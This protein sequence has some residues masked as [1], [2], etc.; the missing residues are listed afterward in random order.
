MDALPLTE[1]NN[2]PYKSQNDGVM[3]ACGHDGHMSELL[4]AAKI[5]NELK[6]N[7]KGRY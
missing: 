5:L 7:F 3:H 2:V 4:A 1:T 6:S